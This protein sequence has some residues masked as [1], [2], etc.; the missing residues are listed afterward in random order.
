MKFGSYNL[1]KKTQIP[2]LH[3]RFTNSGCVSFQKIALTV[4][5]TDTRKSTNRL[6]KGIE[7]WYFFQ[8]HEEGAVL[9]GF[10]LLSNFSHPL[11]FGSVEFVREM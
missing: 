2:G 8:G 6:K 5:N 10:F 11:Q 3:K 7:A 4:L 1:G 9:A